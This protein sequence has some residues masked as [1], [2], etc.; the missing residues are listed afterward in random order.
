[1][2]VGHH[3]AWQLAWDFEPSVVVATAVV[4]GVY[5][6]GMWRRGR[7]RRAERGQHAMFLAG[8]AFAYL[9]LESPLDALADHLFFMHQVQH[10][11]LMSIV[12]MLVVLAAPQATL[13][14]GLAGPLRRN[15]LAPVMANRAVRATFGMLVH[16]VT[17]G[18][19]M[20][21]T[22]YFWQVPRFHDA[23]VRDESIHYVMH[24]T[25]L[26]AGLAFWWPVLDRR[27]PP[28]GLGYL[29]RLFMLKAN[30]MMVVFLG[31]Y[32]TAKGIVLYDV[33]DRIYMPGL[34]ALQDEMLGGA[35]LWF[36]G[37]AVMF[38]GAGMVARG[39]RRDAASVTPR[40]GNASQSLLLR[41]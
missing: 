10:L 40:I 17:A 19:V 15:V 16:P 26:A 12:P 41:T 30:V 6:R 18:V 20:S 27:A 11:F 4:A 5:A 22:L 33:Y 38:L 9:V 39:W 37:A 7:R 35:V 1:M 2:S 24:M 14:A 21:A 29:Y 34:T 31:V 36:G 32:L 28:A 13:T 23:A 3:E 8:T 25:M